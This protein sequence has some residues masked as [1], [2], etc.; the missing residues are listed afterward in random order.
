M[1]MPSTEA[2]WKHYEFE[3]VP[4]TANQTM[5]FT[6]F[7]PALNVDYLNTGRE[8]IIIVGVITYSDGFPDDADQQW[9]FCYGNAMLS[10]SKTMIWTVCDSS[11]YLPEAI[12]EDHYPNNEYQAN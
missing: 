1:R 8:Q 9:P 5:S 10:Q 6:I 11:L 2:H 3:S 7:I 4:A 12:K